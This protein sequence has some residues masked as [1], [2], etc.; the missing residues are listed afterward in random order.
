VS[1]VPRISNIIPKKAGIRAVN[2]LVSMYPQA[3]IEI[4]AIEFIKLNF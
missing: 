2:E 4:S 3:D 1:I